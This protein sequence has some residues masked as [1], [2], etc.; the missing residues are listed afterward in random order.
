MRS[1]AC[2]RSATT[3]RSRPWSTAA[4]QRFAA[5]WCAAGTPNS[6]CEVSLPDLLAA[7]PAPTRDSP[8]PRTGSTVAR[9]LKTEA[10]VLRSIRYAEADRVLHLYTRAARPRERDRQGRAQD[11]PRASAAG[12]SRSPMPR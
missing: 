3:R 8:T 4:L 10:V 1:G 11:R 7:L 2:R 5:I 6:V 9:S 12:W